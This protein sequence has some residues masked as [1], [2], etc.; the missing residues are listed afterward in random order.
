MEEYGV[1]G[2]TL[3]SPHY[4]DAINWVY[5][6][7]LVLAAVIGV[8]GWFAREPAL[9]VWFSRLMVGAHLVYAALDFGHSDSALG[10]GLYR[11]DA[12]VVPGIVAVVVLLLFV[13][14]SVRRE[15]APLPEQPVSDA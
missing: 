14:P 3:T 8:V 10:N 6:H 5:L 13:G 4:Q 7:T 1:P 15:P 9:K 12:S 2:E 11:G